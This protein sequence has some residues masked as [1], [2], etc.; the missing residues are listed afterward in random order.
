MIRLGLQA[1]QKLYDEMLSSGYD[2]DGDGRISVAELAAYWTEKPELA[3]QEVTYE[4]SY[5]PDAAKLEAV[6]VL[7]TAAK[8]LTQDNLNA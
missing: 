1:S 6:S 5:A 3:A 4:Q 8:A 2:L 7:Q